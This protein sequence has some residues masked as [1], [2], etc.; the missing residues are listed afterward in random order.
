MSSTRV[1]PQIR[2]FPFLPL[3]PRKKTIPLRFIDVGKA[4]MGETVDFLHVEWD[5]EGNSRIEK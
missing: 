2:N 3:S 4:A 5:E 1:Q